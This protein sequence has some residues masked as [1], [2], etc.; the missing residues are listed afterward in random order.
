MS[1]FLLLY[2]VFSQG[3]SD[4]EYHRLYGSILRSTQLKSVGYGQSIVSASQ[5]RDPLTAHTDALPQLIEQIKLG[6]SL[7]V[8]AAA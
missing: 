4:D 5:R 3:S 7:H 6:E 1:S 8:T 2:L